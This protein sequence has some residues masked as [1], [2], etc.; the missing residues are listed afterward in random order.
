MS[1][2]TNGNQ[3]VDEFAV[4]DNQVLNDINFSKLFQTIPID[5]K[6]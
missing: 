1:N 4:T 3:S 5:S 2:T 6:N